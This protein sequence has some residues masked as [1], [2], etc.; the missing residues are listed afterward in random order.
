MA[1]LTVGVALAGFW[2]LDRTGIWNDEAATWAISGHSLNDLVH[3]L[4]SSGGDRGAALYYLLEFGWLRVFGTSEFAMR[5]LSVVAAA[6]TMVPFHAVA[7]RLLERPAAVAAGALLAS[8]VFYLTYAREARAYA[9]AM[10]LVVLAAW[11]FLRAFASDTTREWW[12]FTAVALLAL[13]THWFS[14][15]VVLSFFL[16]LR[17]TCSE[18]SRRRHVLGSAAALALGMVPVAGL[19]LSGSNSGVDWIADLNA[20]ELRQTAAAFTG[21]T[22][23][24]SQLVVLVVVGIGLG[25]AWR[26][27]RRAGAPPLALTWF[28]VPV[29]LTVLV[30]IVKPL[31][32]PRY[33]IIALPGLALLLGLG[34][35]QLGRRRLLAV[36]AV[37]VALIALG[38]S[39]YDR[40]WSGKGAEDWQAITATVA[41]RAGARD[42][43]IV[44]P[45]TSAYAFSYYARHDA[46]LS[47]R[48][49]TDWPPRRW[50]APFDRRIPNAA[51]LASPAL[52]SRGAVWLVI[53][54][55][56]GSTVTKAVSDSPVL[57]ELQRRLA[58]RFAVVDEIAPWS[59]HD[60]V[61]VVRYSGPT[62]P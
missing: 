48:T 54:A 30:S 45:A 8:S 1:I 29:A 2:H 13:Y 23:V 51:V 52:R 62:T 49:G 43:I 19:V 11:T 6:G 60:T 21:S 44:F 17:W 9:L 50:D 12:I 22:D 37:T 59:H 46:R 10:L 28:V 61:Y 16:A 56:R 36:A 47:D 35:Y 15:L 27:R 38:A 42:A 31:L 55:P 24:A 26:H 40:V 33:L 57:A 20:A 58:R 14:A 4:R 32:V 41:R 5:S 3:T 39:G 34:A 7:R 25:A 53:R 18:A